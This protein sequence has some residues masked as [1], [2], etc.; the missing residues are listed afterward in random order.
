MAV[1]LLGQIGMRQ[2]SKCSGTILER[3]CYHTTAGKTLPQ[4]AAIMLGAECAA[5][6][7]HHNGECLF[8][9]LCGCGH[10][11]IKAV[12]AH[13]VVFHVA[14][15]GLRGP[16]GHVFGF[17]YTLPRLGRLW[18]LP[19]QVAHGGCCIRNGFIHCY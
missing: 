12:F 16:L 1:G 5:M 3:Y 19:S 13:H 7:E 2:K 10:T 8:G 4:V 17:K 15:F 18:C 6:D 14:L 9:G 11:E